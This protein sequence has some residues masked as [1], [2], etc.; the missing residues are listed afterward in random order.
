MCNIVVVRPGSTAFDEQERIKG[1]LDMPLSAAGLPN[2]QRNGK[3]SHFRG[4]Q[5]AM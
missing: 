5:W 2:R 4:L 1:C 3:P